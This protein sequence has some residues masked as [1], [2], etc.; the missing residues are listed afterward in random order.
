MMTQRL[1]EKGFTEEEIKAR[2]NAQMG[3]EEKIRRADYVVDNSKTLK[4][5]KAAVEKIWRELRLKV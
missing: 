3:L 4:E 1:K 5:T 2:Q